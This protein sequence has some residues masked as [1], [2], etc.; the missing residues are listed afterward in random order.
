MFSSP[1]LAE[2]LED[3]AIIIFNSS[4]DPLGS[5]KSVELLSLKKLKLY[6]PISI[7]TAT[8][9]SVNPPIRALVAGIGLFSRI[10]VLRYPN[11]KSFSRTS[12][13]ISGISWVN[14][15]PVN[16]EISYL[17]TRTFAFPS[18]PL[19]PSIPS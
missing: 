12:A 13:V 1:V 9:T 15:P 3:L 2:I 14:E 7:F 19:V 6:F 4:I 17:K 8:S 16:W 11:I 18:S 5:N 10:L